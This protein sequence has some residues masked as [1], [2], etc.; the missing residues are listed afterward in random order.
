MNAKPSIYRLLA[1]LLAS[2]SF[3]GCMTVNNYGVQPTAQSGTPAAQRD[4]A[5]R[6]GSDC[7]CRNG[8]GGV[9]Y[10]PA[11]NYQGGYY[12]GGY[13]PQYPYYSGTPY[14]SGA[15]YYAPPYYAPDYGYYPP[16]R[17]SSGNGSMGERAGSDDRSSS[18]PADG[19][20]G[21]AHDIGGYAGN[22][23]G[24]PEGNGASVRRHRPS[25]ANGPEATIKDETPAS[26]GLG[27]HERR[28]VDVSTADV[29]QHG[30]QD[31]ASRVSVHGAG[32]GSGATRHG[33]TRAG[34]PSHGD[35]AS[36]GVRKNEGTHYIGSGVGS[37]TTG[38]RSQGVG[39]RSRR[40]QTPPTDN[41]HA[42]QG[43]TSAEGSNAHS[44]GSGATGQPAN[45][46]SA[47][48]GSGGDA[49]A[50]SGRQRNVGSAT[51]SRGNDP[52]A[53]AAEGSNAHSI[54]S[55]ATRQPAN[56]GSAPAGSGGDAHAVSGRQRNAGSATVSRGNDPHAAASGAKQSGS[57][58]AETSTTGADNA[59]VH[60]ATGSSA[61]SKH[62]RPAQDS[63]ANG[64]HS[65]DLHS[66]GTARATD[67][68]PA[69]ADGSDARVNP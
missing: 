32:A 30:D 17:P 56:V 38:S 1:G 23:D 58:P 64:S 46:G 29:N 24:I 13:Y 37:A 7:G 35:S 52:H 59:D 6:D 42:A 40:S 65:T 63:P 12:S 51:V 20:A 57:K 48:A 34:A 45:V 22:D 10:Y 18:Q 44:I 4:V 21:S 11:P 33:G 60:T 36:S 68:A 25:R 41:P 14:Y 39:A 66:A 16:Y 67:P 5:S 8:Q 62:D 19:S 27:S 47:P 3:V 31:T 69:R 54:G 61:G 28:P 15:P 55:G 49:H 9:S 2:L 43:G 50:V 53:A 26:S